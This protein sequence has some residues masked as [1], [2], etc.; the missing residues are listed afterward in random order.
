MTNISLNCNVIGICI[1]GVRNGS[2]S[3]KDPEKAAV[4]NIGIVD[5]GL[6]MKPP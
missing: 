4:I 2:C 5:D 6:K 1:F 3:Q